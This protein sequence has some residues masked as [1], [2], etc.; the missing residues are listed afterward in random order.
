MVK[1][2][3]KGFS[4][5]GKSRW[6]KWSPIQKDHFLETEKA[7]M[8]KG[9]LTRAERDIL[10]FLIKVRET[11]KKNPANISAW[12]LVNHARKFVRR[13]TIRGSVQHV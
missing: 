9:Y 2:V 4:E 1:K 8:A 10:N 12:S 3:I 11:E 5:S 7:R 6:D 13:F